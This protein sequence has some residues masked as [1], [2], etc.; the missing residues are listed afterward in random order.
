MLEAQARG[1]GGGLER[2]RERPSG[3]KFRGRDTL[4]RPACLP[5]REDWPMGEGRL[6]AH[7]QDT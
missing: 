7:L 4:S 6:S 1:L 3:K 2:G 5:C